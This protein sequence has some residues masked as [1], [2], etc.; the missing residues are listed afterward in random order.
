[1]VKLPIKLETRSEWKE[2]LA[3]AV[4]TQRTLEAVAL[5]EEKQTGEYIR[6]IVLLQAQPRSQ[7]RETLRNYLNRAFPADNLP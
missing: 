2:V 5:E 1:M 6:P 3:E 4:K 7:T